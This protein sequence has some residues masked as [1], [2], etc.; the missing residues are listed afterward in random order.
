M[1]SSKSNVCVIFLLSLFL[2]LLFNWP[3]DKSQVAK[4]S[5][6]HGQPF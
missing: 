3:R 1:S 2:L 6:R 4:L 5:E